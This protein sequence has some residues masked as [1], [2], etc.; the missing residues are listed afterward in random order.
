MR[1]DKRTFLAVVTRVQQHWKDR[2][3]HNAKFGIHKRVAVT[4]VYLSTGSTIDS[5]ASLM[6]M[7]K[8]SAVIYINQ[9]LKV[10]QRMARHVIYMPHTEAEI[11]CVRTGFERISGFPDVVGAVDGS[12]IRIS[13]P[14]EHEGWYCRKN[15]PAVNMQAVVDHTTRFRSY[16][17][18]AGS[19]NDQALWNQSG[20][21]NNT[22]IPS[23]MHLLGDAGYKIFRHILTPFDEAD[24]ASSPKKRRYNYKLSQTRITVERAFGILKN[25]YRIL[26]GK[27]QQKTPTSVARV[28]VSCL[29]LH[30]LMVELK[31]TYPVTG[32]DPERA[33]VPVLSALA[34][35][36]ELSHAQGL[37]KQTD[38][39]EY[40][41]SL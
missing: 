14:A 13:R 2:I 23:G 12:L 20:L 21:R 24:A 19:I 15:F 40:L 9:V 39:M 37:A 1:C 27:V 22:L 16:C 38:I 28:I 31:D 4:L 3:H 8:S 5:A 29:V 10:L 26:L 17:I 18:R 7:S 41:F 30:N 32:Q 36:D 33:P 35:E 25:R 34:S 11:T 6:G